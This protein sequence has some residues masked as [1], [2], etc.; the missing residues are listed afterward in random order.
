M[1]IPDPSPYDLSGG[2][3][4][5]LPSPA[6]ENDDD[7]ASA[8]EAAA[9]AVEEA[10]AEQQRLDQSL[11]RC[12]ICGQGVVDGRPLLRFMP[13]NP[14]LAALTIQALPQPSPATSMFSQ[15]ICL[16]IFCGKTASI[17]PTVNQPELEIL[18]KAGL[19]NKHGIGAEVNGALAR[20][21]CANIV[22]IQG[23][24]ETTPPAN[25][26]EKQYYLVREFELHLAAIRSTHA[27][28][29]QDPDEASAPRTLNGTQ[30]GPLTATQMSIPSISGITSMHGN[31][32]T[33]INTFPISGSQPTG[34]MLQTIN[35]SLQN[36]LS[37][38]TVPNQHPRASNCMPNVAAP[39][40]V[41]S[42]VAGMM[43]GS[44]PAM[45]GAP[46]AVSAAAAAGSFAGFPATPFRHVLPQQGNLFVRY[47]GNPMLT[48]QQGMPG[49]MGQVTIPPPMGA[50]PLPPQLP[51][52][53]HLA[54]P[55]QN[56]SR[57]VRPQQVPGTI[58]EASASNGGGANEKSTKIIPN[59]AAAGRTISKHSILNNQTLT[60]P[61][62]LT[63][64][65]VAT[66]EGKIKCGCGGT[67]LQSGTPKGAASWRN[68]VV[69]K[70]HQKWIEAQG[71][72]RGNN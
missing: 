8:A 46:M 63:N 64:P 32:S 55:P 4:S 41:V 9:N 60:F 19:K 54:A 65:D 26:Q 71:A 67:Y 70:R 36:P 33:V 42:T 68:H 17:L 23:I 39:G 25:M 56:P 40:T 18:T 52:A 44:Q 38:K 11:L 58:S 62:I 12:R 43:M 5:E 51:H 49:T 30:N 20:T 21:R 15:D 34:A 24:E 16:H 14:S 6:T 61:G 53:Q 7:I 50:V 2:V 22:P 57:V 29:A 28:G 45:L 48:N 72:V 27:G 1:Q 66:V 47:P 13:M 31:A 69:T 35:G 10:D 3:A 59:H 37:T